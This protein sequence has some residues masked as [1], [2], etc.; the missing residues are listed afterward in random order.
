[1]P[2]TPEI[3]PGAIWS[4]G[5]REEFRSSAPVS[6]FPAVT[7]LPKPSGAGPGAAAEPW[8]W[9]GGSFVGPRAARVRRCGGWEGRGERRVEG[10]GTRSEGKKKQEQK[11]K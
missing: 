10:E 11:G 5:H 9:G 6:P 7:A 2:R 4:S 1:M 8:P 3:F